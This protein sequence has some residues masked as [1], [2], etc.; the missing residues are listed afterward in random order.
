QRQDTEQ[1]RQHGDALLIEYQVKTRITTPFQVQQ[2]RAASEGGALITVVELLQLLRNLVT[3]LRQFEQTQQVTRIGTRLFRVTV[4]QRPEMLRFLYQGFL[5]QH[6]LDDFCRDPDT[7]HR[8][9]ADQQQ[10]HDKHTGKPML[11][12]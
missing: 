11:N 4:I 8:R 2:R 12:A 9:Q 5:E 3:T 10:L 7:Q 6:L 1:E